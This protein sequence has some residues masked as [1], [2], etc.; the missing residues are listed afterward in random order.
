MELPLADTPVRLTR[1]AWSSEIRS[2]AT[3]VLVVRVEATVPA[4]GGSL[5]DVATLAGPLPRVRQLFAPESLACRGVDLSL[6]SILLVH[7]ATSD[8][9][10]L[11]AARIR[12]GALGG[13]IP[14]AVNVRRV[15][16]YQFEVPFPWGV[17]VVGAED[18]GG[19]P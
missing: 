4:S 18:F 14:G 8:L 16:D 11:G 6:D 13:A 12:D 7:V 1:E 5:L 2:D 17:E 19:A 10:R 15:S 3:S 9:A